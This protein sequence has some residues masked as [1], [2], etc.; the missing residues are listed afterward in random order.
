MDDRGQG[1]HTENTADD[2]DGIMTTI[3]SQVEPF[4][5]DRCSSIISLSDKYR[6]QEE[7]EV[8]Q[9]HFHYNLPPEPIRPIKLPLQISLPT[10]KTSPNAQDA[11]LPNGVNEIAMEKEA[12]KNSEEETK[13]SPA[14][15]KEN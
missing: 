15:V 1:I 9:E 2:G 6:T 3:S 5:E 12:R 10:V 13:T 11:N 14:L 8:F 7:V 4:S